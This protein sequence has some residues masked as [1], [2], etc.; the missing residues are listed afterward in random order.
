MLALALWGEGGDGNGFHTR[1]LGVASKARAAIHMP[2]NSAQVADVLEYCLIWNTLL[3]M[4][5]NVCADSVGN[6]CSFAIIFVSDS[7]RSDERGV[8]VTPL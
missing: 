2:E 1:D 6:A 8:E 5:R 3:A 7:S 4:A